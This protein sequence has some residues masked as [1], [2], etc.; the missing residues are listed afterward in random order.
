MAALAAAGISARRGI[1][2]A[3]RQPAYAG[4]DTGGVPLPVTEW[5]TDTTLILPLFHQMSESEQ[6]R[7]IDVLR[8]P[9][10]VL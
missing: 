7:V 1:M 3:H 4:R 9:R 5:L 8:D 10:S 6:G 2:A